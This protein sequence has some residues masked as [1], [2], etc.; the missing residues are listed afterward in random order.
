MRMTNSFGL[1]KK[2]LATLMLA[3]LVTVFMPGC[4]STDD[5]V[6]DGS[7]GAGLFSAEALG[8]DD[9]SV[10]TDQVNIVECEN[11]NEMRRDSL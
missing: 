8:L 6:T 10:F 9:C 3:G 2:L 4:S 11:R 1:S 5:P 7:G